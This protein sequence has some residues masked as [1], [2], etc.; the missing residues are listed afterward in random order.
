MC[1]SR[2]HFGTPF[3]LPSNVRV[4]DCSV[5]SSSIWY[6]TKFLEEEAFFLIFDSFLLTTYEKFEQS[7]FNLT[8]VYIPGWRN[9][10]VK[11]DPRTIWKEFI[12]RSQ[13][14]C[15]FINFQVL[16]GL[17]CMQ[18]KWLILTKG[19]QLDSFIVRTFPRID[20]ESTGIEHSII[21]RN[22]LHWQMICLFYSM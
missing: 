20:S 14:T 8:E 19:N 7:S 21:I 13:L 17:S 4:T 9:N 22:E 5:T 1:L 2:Y 10:R 11:S 18:R 15:F 3:S 16:W 6:W 12:T